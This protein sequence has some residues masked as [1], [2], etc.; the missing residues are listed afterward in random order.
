MADDSSNTV[1]NII[2]SGAAMRESRFWLLILVVLI[3]GGII[4]LG[5]GLSLLGGYLATVGGLLI[6]VVADY[7][8]F[9]RG[10]LEYTTEDQG[11][12]EGYLVYIREFREG[13]VVYIDS[14]IRSLAC[15]VLAILS[16]LA[17]ILQIPILLRAAFTFVG[18]FVAVL[19]FSAA[20]LHAYAKIPESN[21]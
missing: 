21:Q 12:L 15:I 10:A 9:L 5:T 16:P 1:T 4:L 2:T 13:R 20:P 7:F 6:F 19:L 8:S 14:Y 17:F 3:V 11:L 18:I